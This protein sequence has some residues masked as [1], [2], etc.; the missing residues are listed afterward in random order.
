[1]KSVNSKKKNSASSESRVKSLFFPFYPSVSAEAFFFLRSKCLS[2]CEKLKKRERTRMAFIFI[3]AKMKNNIQKLCRKLF[4]ISPSP[5]APKTIFS[6][7][8]SCDAGGLLYSV[9]LFFC[10]IYTFIRKPKQNQ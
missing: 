3:C 9:L 2:D 4:P 10:I 6:Y 5:S 7:Q 1:M 8:D